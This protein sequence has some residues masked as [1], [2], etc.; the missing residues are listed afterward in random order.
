M[1]VQEMSR[2]M[3]DSLQP[4]A[5][6]TD[7][8]EF[9][10]GST[11]DNDEVKNTFGDPQIGTYVSPKKKDAYG[12]PRS[13]PVYEGPKGGK[14]YISPGGNKEYGLPRFVDIEPIVKPSIE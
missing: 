2:S 3:T 1:V 6:E 9:V 10:E 12:N 8:M 11:I 4:A 7:F 5:T 14:Y 13:V